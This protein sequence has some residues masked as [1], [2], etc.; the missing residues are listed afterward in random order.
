MSSSR[1]HIVGVGVIFV[2]LTT[3]STMMLTIALL[4]WLA[5]AL[6]SLLGALLLLGV[7]TLLCSLLLYFSALRPHIE[8]FNTQISAIST[9]A[10]LIN[11]VVRLF[12]R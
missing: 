12:R 1:N 9:L 4:L 3:L 8:S 2:A 5:S 10:H 6:G 11:G 7:G